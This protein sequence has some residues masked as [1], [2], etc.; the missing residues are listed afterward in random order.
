MKKKLLALSIGA[1]LTAATVPAMSAELKISGRAHLSV[2]HIDNGASGARGAADAKKSG[3]TMSSN[4]S[5]LRVS[6]SKE[7]TEGLTAIM[8]LEQ[9]VRFDQSG[10][11][12]ATRDSFAGLKGDFGTVRLGFFDTPLKKVRSFTDMFGDR[13][14]DARNI[15][16]GD[17][18]SF[19]NRFRNGIGYTTPNLNGF[20]L[21]LQYSATNEA[22]AGSNAQLDNGREAYSAAL[23]YRA[24]GLRMSAAVESLGQG[25]AAS[26]GSKKNDDAVAYRLG[27]TYDFTKELKVAAFYQNSNKRKVFDNNGVLDEEIGSRDVFG[28]G[29][30]YRI[31]DYVVRGQY[32]NASNESGT[33]KTGADMFAV[34]LDRRFGRDLTLYGAY[35][36][37]NNQDNAT[38][39]AVGGG[40]DTRQSA[41]AGKDMSAFSVGLIYNF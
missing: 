5:R 26:T 29:A 2:D 22:D 7:V 20:N 36:M 10:G 18:L 25:Y 9:N 17:N 19:D 8:Q 13:I 15:T 12:F 21:D 40:R 41:V 38:F 34:G 37:T 4:S 39:S 32:Y 6:G 14:G 31:G 35:A 3:L 28:I 24:D 1:A 33:K 16:S 11:Q 27:L 30:S 23:N